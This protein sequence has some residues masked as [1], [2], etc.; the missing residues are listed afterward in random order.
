MTQGH[1]VHVAA[2]IIWRQGRFLAAQ[3]PEGKSRAGFWE[4]PGGKQEAGETL[5]QTLLRE[6]DEELGIRCTA[7]QPWLKLEHSYPEL[8]VSLHF[9]HV[10]AFEGEPE[11]RD[12][13]ALAWLRPREALRLNFLPADRAIIKDLRCP[14]SAL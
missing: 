12:G 8:T 2:G 10:T 14:D 1:L 11:P 5:E 4:F 6:L 3:R 9:I 7:M 13:Q